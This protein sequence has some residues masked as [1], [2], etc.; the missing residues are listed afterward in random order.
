MLL[1]SDL[2]STLQLENLPSIQPLAQ[3]SVKTQP[4]VSHRDDAP[5]H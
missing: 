3:A 5:A 1:D 4:P 2:S